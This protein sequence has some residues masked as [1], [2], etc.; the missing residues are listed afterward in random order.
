MKKVSLRTFMLIQSLIALCIPLYYHLMVIYKFHSNVPL[1]I[2]IVILAIVSKLKK[3]SETMDEYAQKT[4]QIADSI[5]FK[6]SLVLMGI[7]VLPFLLLS[8]ISTFFTGY[9]LTF[10][11]FML[12]LSRACIFW[13]IDKKGMA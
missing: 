10:G 3:A 7:L 11:I 9:L 8:G 5:C 13:W 4:L 12:I 6:L 1:I 2:V